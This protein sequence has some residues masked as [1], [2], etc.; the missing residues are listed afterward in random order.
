MGAEEGRSERKRNERG[1]GRGRRSRR[2]ERRRNR[3]EEKEH[4]PEE[5]EDVPLDGQ[6]H[7]DQRGDWRCF[8]GVIGGD[9]Q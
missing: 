7:V 2:R 6:G 8:L 4:D 1:R 9:L 3:E 5:G